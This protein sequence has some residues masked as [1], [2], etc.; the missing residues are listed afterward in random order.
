MRLVRG[1]VVKSASRLIFLPFCRALV[2]SKMFQMT[3]GFG[4][5]PWMNKADLHNCLGSPGSNRRACSKNAIATVPERVICCFAL[6]Q[7]DYLRA[8]NPRCRPSDH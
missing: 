1:L 6:S 3:F 5:F 7:P 4:H 2:P 8:A